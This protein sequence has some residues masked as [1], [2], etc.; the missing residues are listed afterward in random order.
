ME[1]QRG[2][3]WFG[4]TG[5]VSRYD[6]TRFT[7]FTIDDG[8][9]SNVVYS[10][11]EDREGNLWFGTWEWGEGSGVSRYDGRNFTTFTMK[12]GLAGNTVTT[13]LEDRQGNLW[14]STEG[15]GEGRGVSR[16]DGKEFTTFTNKD[17]LAGNYV[18]S[19]LEDRGGNLWFGTASGGVSRYDGKE[20]ITFTTEDGLAGNRVK[21]ILEDREG[22]LWFGT[23]AGGVS[24]YDGKDFTAFT[25]ED[26][27]ASNQVLTIVEDR[28]GRLWVGTLGA[29]VSRYDGAQFATFT[30]EEGLPNNSVQT[31]TG[32]REGNLWFGT[33]GN[34]SRYDG[35]EWSSLFTGENQ[36]GT[37]VKSIVEDREGNLWLGTQGKGVIRYDGKE[38]TTFTAEDGLASNTAWAILEDRQ[39]NLWFGTVNPEARGVSRYDGK[40]FITL[41]TKDGLADNGVRPI[42]EDQEGNLW[43]GTR[44]GGVSRYDGKEFVNFTT[45][46]GLAS[47]AVW[48]IIEDRKGTL[49]FGAWPGGVSRYDGKE[50]VNFT[51]EDG[52]V[53]NAV[54]SILE[55]REGDLW[56]A[57][58][59]R[60]VSRY[61]GSVFQTLS[62]Q[63]G[64]VNDAV[65]DIFQDRH[66]DMWIATEGGITRYRPSRTP[67][68][69]RILNVAT[70][71]PHGPVAR[72][73]LPTSQDYLLIEFQGVSMHT[74]PER[75]VYLYRL[76]GYDDTWQQTRTGRMEYTDLPLGEYIFQVK[77]VD[78]DLNYSEPVAVE[79]HVHLPYG[80]LGLWSALAISILLV[81]WQTTRV[82]RR[83]HWLQKSNTALSS[84]NKELFQLNQ[85][86]QRERAVERVRAE[87]TA[88]KTPEDLQEVV[89]D[90]LAELETTG[91]D[92]DLCVINIVDEAA[93]VR[94]QFGA[95][96]QGWSGQLEIPLAQASEEFLSIWREGKPVVRPVDEALAA[97]HLETKQQLGIALEG[98]VPTAIAEAPFAYG[99][100]SLSTRKPTG[101][102]PEEEALVAE[103]ARV[104]ALGYARFLDFQHLEEQNQQIQE[105][106]RRMSDFLA[107]MSHDLRTP[108]NAIIGYTRILL[109]RLKDSIESRQLRNLENID[110]SSHNLLNL[111]NEILDLSRVQ[112]GRIDVNPQDI[113]LKQL[114]TECAA[115]VESLVKPD[116]E[117][118]RQI[119]D[120]P[121]VRTDPDVLHK[122]LM[123]LLSN[124]V[125]F[126]D[127][128]SITVAV[129]PVDGRVELSVADTGM[130][131]PP[132]DLP[133]IFEEFRQVE[134]Q[135]ST[136]K[137]GTG[138]GLAIAK[139]SVE[140]LGGTVEAESEEGK[141]TT[142]AI[143]IADYSE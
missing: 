45:E 99:T 8:L 16:Y 108:M 70:D 142:F 47:N 12:D 52:L 97:R 135:G 55:D 131:I 74:P 26:G 101:F 72:V 44:S 37:F 75:M 17:D 80:R 34:V 53:S 73:E 87:V 1:D 3:L 85:A 46:D 109:R 95:T 69:A 32:D 21:S 25:P 124:A 54:L 13:I 7:T 103:F 94:R 56:F 60:G 61:D 27:L 127:A 58:F 139:K 116:V 65:Q 76:E 126:T 128:G 113:D 31:I 23:A 66:G 134:R 10:I 41:T 71:R 38:F 120:V 89:A 77:A 78:R 57:T 18:Q 93:G 140:L 4:T 62:R 11:L 63:D 29:G 125:K 48:A 51:T 36:I 81:A 98:G 136:E 122:V 49:W 40:E 64:L 86:L 35:K 9:A 83:D 107:R 115:S 141:G 106:T 111:I 2:H 138:L 110:T 33:F 121:V 130:G 105:N 102:S 5:G 133:H 88:M 112:A 42:L 82:I 132:E 68:S 96:R 92:F 84:A 19:I 67:P 24:R 20:F 143:R 15:W 28:E 137:E 43:F 6:G 117:L 79:V 129:K 90:M 119:A 91:V 118:V 59:G 39:G 22:N 100:L 30:T 14:F 123:N 104:M 50:F 114:A